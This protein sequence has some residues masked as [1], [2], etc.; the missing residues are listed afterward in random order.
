MMALHAQ[1]EP[2]T[3][4]N[5]QTQGQFSSL[6]PGL[7]VNVCMEIRSD[8]FKLERE[9]ERQ[10]QRENDRD[11]DRERGRE[12]GKRETHR[13]KERWTDRLKYRERQSQRQREMILF[14][15]LKRCLK[16]LQVSFQNKHMYLL[17]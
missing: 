1:Y 15:L 3:C 16:G 5:Q 8:F 14:V 2:H 6:K 10:R 13:E 4:C 9:R 12:R 17:Y 11:R 7:W